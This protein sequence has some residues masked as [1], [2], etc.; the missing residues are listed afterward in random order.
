MKLDYNLIKNILTVIEEHE[1]HE[2]MG[3]ELLEKL[4]MPFNP[5]NKEEVIAHDNLVGH[6][7]LL[8][9]YDCIDTSNK[10]LPYGIME[11]YNYG[12]IDG[13]YRMTNEGYEFLRGL[14]EK[15]IFEKIK[16][17]SISVAVDVVKQ[18]LID[19]TLGKLN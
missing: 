3:N 7:K 12:R 5:A 10:K 2:I 13:P 8:F 11:T 17:L 16:N 6:I 9:D 1:K 15:K 4:D 19:L 14:Q 18:L